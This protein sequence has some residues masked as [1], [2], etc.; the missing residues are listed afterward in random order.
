[1]RIVLKKG[2]L[3][4]LDRTVSTDANGRATIEAGALA[5]GAYQ[6]EIASMSDPWLVWDGDPA[7]YSFSVAQPTRL[8]IERIT[9][10]KF[11]DSLLV[12]FAV[13]NELGVEVSEAVVT[14]DVYKDG[15][16]FSAGHTAVYGA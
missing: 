5:S 12:T 1:M 7:L 14:F 9:L 2:S 4:V 8:A 13:R 10:S 15:V 3:L 6:A 16:L 11:F